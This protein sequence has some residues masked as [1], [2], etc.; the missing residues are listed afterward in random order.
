[1]STHSG[2]INSL[3]GA[4]THDIYL[5]LTGRSADDPQTLLTNE[6]H[7]AALGVANPGGLVDRYSLLLM[8]G[9]MS[10]YM[11]AVLVTRLSAMDAGDYD[12]IGRAR[13][14]EALYLIINSP[15]YSIQK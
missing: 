7:D 12:D 10:P 9:Q 5:P 8:G 14:Q 6:A 4:T 1:M 2:A 3:A 15:E 13:V 11:R